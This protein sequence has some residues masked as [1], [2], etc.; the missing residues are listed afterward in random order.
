MAKKHMCF[1]RVEYPATGKYED[2]NTTFYCWKES[3]HE[4]D[5]ECG[6][7]EEVDATWHADDAP[8]RLMWVTAR[9]QREAV[10]VATP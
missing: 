6:P 2:E 9:W 8:R 5:H 3:G 4:G 1:D 7:I 10:S